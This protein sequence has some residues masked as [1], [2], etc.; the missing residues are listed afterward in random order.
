MLEERNAEQERT[1][2][3]LKSQ[4]LENDNLMN[5]FAEEIRLMDVEIDR[6]QRE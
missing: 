3:G 6:K 1:I 2:Q 5:R 4:V